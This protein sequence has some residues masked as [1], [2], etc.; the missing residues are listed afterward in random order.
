MAKDR[1]SHEAP[2]IPGWYWCRI[3]A[4]E[5][6]VHVDHH[7]IFESE[8]PEPDGLDVS[9]MTTPG[10]TA[11]LHESEWSSETEWAGPIAPPA[12][13]EVDHLILDRIHMRLMALH[14]IVAQE[15]GATPI[16]REIVRKSESIEF[17]DDDGVWKIVVRPIEGGRD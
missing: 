8:G 13:D 14:D 3:Q 6:V 16:Y 10:R 17:I 1:Y 15:Y 12:K 9:W 2:T 7:M 4:W 11:I 5:G